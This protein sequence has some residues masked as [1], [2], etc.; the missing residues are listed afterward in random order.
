MI[1]DFQ[2]KALEKYLNSEI[3]KSIYPMIESIEINR[4]VGMNWLILSIH[5]NDDEI[6]QDN[7]YSKGL[8]PH[9]LTDHY[10]YKFFPYIGISQ[11]EKVGLVI[12]GK[13][14]ERIYGFL[15]R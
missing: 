7:M 10:M 9:Y 13:D 11:N 6:N 2:E 15:P 14:G 12:F 4:L 5:L 3:I 8:D 1:E